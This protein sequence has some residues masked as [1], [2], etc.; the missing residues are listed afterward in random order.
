MPL[1]G[2]FE[3]NNTTIFV[4]DYF[5]RVENQIGYLSTIKK[6][7]FFLFNNLINQIGEEEK[8]N[9]QNKFSKFVVKTNDFPSP[10]KIMLRNEIEIIKKGI[11]KA[12]LNFLRKLSSTYNPIYFEYLAKRISTV[13]VSMINE[14]YVE[15]DF[16]L[17][18]SRGIK[19]NLLNVLE[20]K[21]IKYKITDLRNEGNSLD[22]DFVGSLRNQQKDAVSALISKENGILI[23]PTA[24]GKTVV[25]I[26]LI[27]VLKRNALIIVDKLQ[28]ISQWKEKLLSFSTLTE[29]DIGVYYTSKKNLT[30]KV[31][32]ISFKSLDSKEIDSKIFNNYGI[33]IVDEVHHVGATNYSKIINKFTS[34]RMYGLTATLKRSD[35]NEEIVKKI[36][37][38]VIY[39]AKEIKSAFT[40]YLHPIF[41]NFNVNLDDYLGEKGK[42][43][44]NKLLTSLYLD[45]DR[46]NLILEN[47]E[48]LVGKRNILVLTERI[49][50]G[51]ILFSR[52][53]EKFPNEK[54]FFINGSMSTREKRIFKAQLD[55]LKF[56]DKI[57]I[58]ST[59]KFIGEGFDLDRLDT[60]FVTMPIKWEGTLQQYVGR[61]HR[62]RSGKDEVN[63]YDFVDLKIG[64]FERM[65]N[66]RSAKYRK[67]FY[68]GK[69]SVNPQIMFGRSDYFKAL[70]KDLNEAK[71]KI[72]MFVGF[73]F[74]DAPEQLLKDVKISVNIFTDLEIK[75]IP[76]ERIK[77]FSKKGNANLIIID[78]KIIWFGSLNPF[79]FKKDEEETIM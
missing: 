18:L 68:I 46:N 30:N 64:I 37:G 19:D 24:F 2:K 47:I 38:D 22:T 21:T 77:V 10:L 58:I 39:E 8:E 44:Y 29:D 69:N 6:V 70:A 1:S 23:A 7:D 3:K 42:V 72:D 25:A 41:T 52:L 65:F 13:N 57:T 20:A 67:L 76:N 63:V 26:N 50:H 14:L 51:D 55:L 36:V 56:E 34:K 48:P 45:E 32:I 54:I 35:K 59:G 73:G 33:V 40:R 62:E 79:V 27:S 15:D 71:T 49:E 17:F 66:S 12:G 60:L 43:D 31:D 61:L 5:E 74:D 4:D 53:K 9:N 16:S 11:S 28:L 75:N 78:E